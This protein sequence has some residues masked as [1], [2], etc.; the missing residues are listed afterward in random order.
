VCVSVCVCVCV[1]LGAEPSTLHILGKP[2]T[3]QL[4]P[5]LFVELFLNI[6]VRENETVHLN[7]YL[8]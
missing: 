7:F 2:F 4:Y 1:V 5:Q 6:T 8:I 3:T